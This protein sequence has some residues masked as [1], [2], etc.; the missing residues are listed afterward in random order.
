MANIGLVATA[1]NISSAPLKV[2]RPAWRDMSKYYPGEDISR[3][4]LYPMISKALMNTVRSYENSEDPD[5][6]PYA[7]TCALRMS[8]ALNHSGVRLE[9]APSSGG[10]VIGDDGKNYWIR[11][12]DLE[13]ELR[14]RFKSPDIFY[15]QPDFPCAN[16]TIQ[17]LKDRATATNVNIISK[18]E[19]KN[20]IVV[21]KVSG[22]GDATGHFTLWDC[23][24]KHLLY[25]G[26]NTEENNSNSPLYY[27]WMVPYYR[28][29]GCVQSI[30]FWELK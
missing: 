4:N 20:G 5:R 25:V 14:K 1:G 6:H 9:K 23:K 10:T 26:G 29:S 3:E 8:Y 2:H 15:K 7:N 13:A 24:L 27:F 12:K 22:W 18:I 17:Q 21:F 16:W 19:D 11:V 30:S 28:N